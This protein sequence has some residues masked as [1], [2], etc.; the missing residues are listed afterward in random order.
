MRIFNIEKKMK[1]LFIKSLLIVGILFVPACITPEPVAPDTDFPVN[2]KPAKGENNVSLAVTLTWEGN[3]S[4][5]YDV[6]FGSKNPPT[7]LLIKDTTAKSVVVT[8]LSYSTTYYWRV[9]AKSSSGKIKSG[10]VWYFTTKSQSSNQPG[11]ALTK[12]IIETR[13]PC[14]VNIMFQVTDMDGKGVKNLSKEDFEV[15]ENFQPIS[16]T[17]SAINIKKRDA[18]PYILK[19]VL[20]IDNSSSVAAD[21]AIIKSAAISLV[22]SIVPQQEIAIYKF[23]ESVIKVQDF[24]S[25]RT[26]LTSAINS[27]DVGLP[28]TNLYGAVLEGVSLWEE[29]Y[30]LNEIQQGFLLLITDG[31]DTQSSHT[32]GEALNKR[33]NKKIY[34][35][36]LGSEIDPEALG[37]L[38]NAG[39]VSINDVNLLALSFSQIQTQMDDY[40]NSFYLL[41]YMSPK[42]GNSNHTIQLS[43]KG[44]LNSGVNSTIM[45]E[46]NSSGFTSAIKGIY[47]NLSNEKPSG[48]DTIYLRK[49][50]GYNLIAESHLPIGTPVYEWSS[51]NNS[52]VVINPDQSSNSRVEIIALGDSNTVVIIKV[53]DVVNQLE[54][55]LFVF[56]TGKR[57]FSQFFEAGTIPYGWNSGG[58]AKWYIVSDTKVK[59]GYS[60][61][62]GL[63]GD[64]QQTYIQATYA[65]PVNSNLTVSFYRKV[66]S[67]ENYDKLTFYVNNAEIAS[68][69]GESNWTKFTYQAEA[70]TGAVTLKW[71][72]KKDS[73]NSIGSDCCWID[74]IVVDW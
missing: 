62:S 23:S 32:L 41:N 12:H 47:V 16:P 64:N 17:E 27:L 14:F 44:N 25:D 42:R 56:I 5:K 48:I 53:K 70:T 46:F 9:V 35:I 72:Y 58:N 37:I 59:G 24:T 55:D 68:W 10:E 36:G 49:G 52:D 1:N 61:K 3:Q 45:G 28:S 57:Y 2:P 11:Y 15:K 74:D 33:G 18:V 60:A 38:G 21:L 67:E 50:E 63:I 39:F 6:Y 8:G 51:S 30:N 66:S 40:A 73:K 29:F 65:I 71:V 43:V 69:S 19:T 54:R 34:T 26:I 20:M 4:D 31:R 22:N 13:Y 7:E